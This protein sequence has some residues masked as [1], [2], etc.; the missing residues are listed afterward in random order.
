MENK[1]K[2][3]IRLESFRHELLD[4]SY[5]KIITVLQNVPLDSISLVTLPT[6]NRIFCV[7]RSPH[8]DKDSREHFEIR[9]HKRV[10]TV[11]ANVE[12]DVVG[13]LRKT[14][15]PSGVT[16]KIEFKNL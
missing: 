10:L 12:S 8:V 11:V 14:S 3:Q 4:S 15:L 1:E 16:Y 9:T 5:K 2:L 13:L 6:T 7:L